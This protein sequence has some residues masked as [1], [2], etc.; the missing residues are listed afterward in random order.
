MSRRRLFRH[1][2]TTVFIACEGRNT[3]PG[4]LLG[5]KEWLEE[6]DPVYFAITIYPDKSEKKPKSDPLGLIKEARERSDEFD[7]LWVMFDKNGYTLHQKA[8]EEAARVVNG[9]KVNIA[10]SSISF[11]Q[12]V[13]LHFERSSFAFSKSVHIIEQRLTGGPAYFP[14]Y[15]KR[16]N[17]NSFPSLWPFTLNAIRN[18]AWLRHFQSSRGNRSPVYELNPYT[19]ADQL[20]ARLTGIPDRWFFRLEGEECELDQR[21]AIRADR[22]SPG[23]VLV[24]IT[25]NQPVAFSTGELSWQSGSR[26][27]ADG[28]HPFPHSIIEPGQLVSLPVSMDAKYLIIKLKFSYLEIS[29]P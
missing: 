16:P 5:L 3:E 20:I 23:E 1:S 18:A 19:N 13:L 8:F 4:Y 7:E 10:F 21:I 22:G 24:S 12:W 11:E 26:L 28:Y 14:G 27:Q 29:L 15:D 6:Q 17:L 2:P 9:K 25:N